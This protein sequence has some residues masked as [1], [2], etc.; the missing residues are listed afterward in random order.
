MKP[1]KAHYSVSVI[2]IGFVFVALLLSSLAEVPTANYTIPPTDEDALQRLMTDIFDQD[3]E[4]FKE[5]CE[6]EEV[7]A[8]VV[9]LLNENDGAGWDVLEKMC[10]AREAVAQNLVSGCILDARGLLSSKFFQ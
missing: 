6:A 9:N 4:E 8:S 3:M 2:Q 1:F 7:W 10:F 5:Y